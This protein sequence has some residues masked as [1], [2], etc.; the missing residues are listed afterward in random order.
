MKIK[1]HQPVD[2]FIDYSSCCQ[3]SWW[4]ILG[5]ERIY[6]EQISEEEVWG[7]LLHGRLQLR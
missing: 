5:T 4:E 6:P 7:I 1:L 2:L 3:W